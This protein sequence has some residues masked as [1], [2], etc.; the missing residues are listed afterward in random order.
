MVAALT[1]LDALSADTFSAAFI[2]KSDGVR[3]STLSAPGPDFTDLAKNYRL[4]ACEPVDVTTV[5]RLVLF[6]SE[7]SPFITVLFNASF[8]DDI[9][10]SSQQC[11]VVTLVLKKP[12]LDA[13]DAAN[14]GRS[15]ISR[16]CPS[17]LS[18][19]HINS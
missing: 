15:L 4:H 10:P 19:A 7:L 3:S 12:T 5:Q 16:F 8:R 9:F 1:A 6:A 13:C 11:V 2:A 17:C 18:A 14:T